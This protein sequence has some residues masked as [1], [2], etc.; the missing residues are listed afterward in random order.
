MWSSHTL[1]YYSAMKRKEILVPNYRWVNLE[2][3]MLSEM[4][5]HR[6]HTAG[7]YLEVPKSSELWCLYGGFL[8]QNRKSSSAEAQCPPLPVA[9]WWRQ[10]PGKDRSAAHLLDRSSVPRLL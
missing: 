5:R 3:Q 7:C 6:T 4:S 1:D 10:A 2:D 9:S 8:P